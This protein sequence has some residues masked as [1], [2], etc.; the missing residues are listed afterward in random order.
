MKADSVNTLSN[1]RESRALFYAKF[2]VFKFMLFRVLM[3][4]KTGVLFHCFILA[5]GIN[6]LKKLKYFFLKGI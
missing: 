6:F 1:V 3:L 4:A 2:F 5:G